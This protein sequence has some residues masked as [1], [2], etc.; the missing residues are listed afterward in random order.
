MTKCLMMIFLVLNF[1]TA[2]SQTKAG[3]VIL[4]VEGSFGSFDG[5][6]YANVRGGGKYLFT[7]SVALGGA[8]SFSKSGGTDA[9]FGLGINFDYLVNR[10][11]GIQK[12]L[13]RAALWW[14]LNS[15]TDD[16]VKI[17]GG[18]FGIRHYFNDSVGLQ[19]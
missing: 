10:R 7:N 16:T 13:P 6:A 3:A 9:A 12:T 15:Q 4:D 2:H 1:Q 5:S 19:A 18:G 8:V 11:P 17:V 14:F